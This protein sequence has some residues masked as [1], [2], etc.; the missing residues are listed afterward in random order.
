MEAYHFTVADVV[1]QEVI[2]KYLTLI[3]ASACTVIL[4]EC[5]TFCLLI[6]LLLLGANNNH[7]HWSLSTGM[8]RERKKVSMSST[9]RK[10]RDPATPF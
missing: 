8:R 3:T 6:S 9:S 10:D 1:L 7:E 4:V 2:R 5:Q